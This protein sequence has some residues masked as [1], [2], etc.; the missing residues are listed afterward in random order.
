MRTPNEHAVGARREMTRRAFLHATGL[1]ALATTWP[2][3]SAWAENDGAPLP[4]LQSS[5]LRAGGVGA[6]VE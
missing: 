6:G 5:P 3:G 4:A 1:A 2:Y